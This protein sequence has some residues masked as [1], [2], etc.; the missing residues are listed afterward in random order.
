MF[1]MTD[2]FLMNKIINHPMT[3]AQVVSSL[4]EMFKHIILTDKLYD[5]STL[6][7]VVKYLVKLSVRH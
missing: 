2:Y 4:L 6:N 3:N 1:N 7:F 5:Y